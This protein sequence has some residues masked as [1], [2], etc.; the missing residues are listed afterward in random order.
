MVRISHCSSTGWRSPPEEKL[1]PD[2]ANIDVVAVREGVMALG[3]EFSS[4]KLEG[5]RASSGATLAG[6]S[7][8]PGAGFVAT[9][10]ATASSVAALAEL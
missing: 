4:A 5:G 1:Y 6:V 7:V 10:I 3:T 9:I 8:V 2:P